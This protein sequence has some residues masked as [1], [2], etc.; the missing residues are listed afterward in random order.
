MNINISL[1]LINWVLDPIKIP[2]EQVADLKEKILASLPGEELTIRL[3][4]IFG[5]TQPA[6]I[7][8]LNEI[9]R[10]IGKMKEK[11]IR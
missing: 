6:T 11:L 8:R 2:P 7:D 5:Q 10:L 3:E 4:F 1:P 9:D